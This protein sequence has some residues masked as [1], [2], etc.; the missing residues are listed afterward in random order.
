M[1]LGIV[2]AGMIVRDL[3][4]FIHEIPAITLEAICS[5]PGHLEQL[6]SLQEQYGITRIY[7]EYG[8]M[9]AYDE[10]DTIY[11]GLPNH[12]HYAYAKE[13]LLGGKHV[14]CE[15]PFTSNLQEFLELKEIAQQNELVLVEAI[16]NQYLKNYLSMK[17]YLPKLGDIKIVECNYSQ[18]SSRYAAFQAGE[19]LPVFNP[20]MSGG[21]LMDIN[22]YNIHLVVGLFGSPKK[23]DYWANMERGIDT[24]GML[25]LDYGEFKCVCIGSKDSSA[26]NAMN[27]QGNKGYIHMTSSAN[28]CESFDLALHMETLVRVDHKDHPHRM[29]DEFVEFERIIREQDLEK[30]TAMLKHSE[31]VMEVIEQAK[32][33]ANLV[34]GPDL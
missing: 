27:I 4:S 33:S 28:K 16:S 11:I 23:V 14:I 12:L 26:P 3:L 7:S 19:V 8:D 6:L 34:F 17:E 18:Y 5:R 30:V 24:S 2:G 32:Q 1:K 21:A 13:A 10:V 15:K 31:K 29:Y 20:K 22:L 9:I 25:L